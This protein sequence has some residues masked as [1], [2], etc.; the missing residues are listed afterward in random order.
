[1]HLYNYVYSGNIFYLSRV[2]LGREERE[3][4]EEEGVE[5]GGWELEDVR[6]C[7]TRGAALLE[8]ETLTLTLYQLPLHTC[9]YTSSCTKLH[10]GDFKTHI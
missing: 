2:T 10:R 7:F 6:G 4:E 3:R 8:I 5:G 9:R 1:M